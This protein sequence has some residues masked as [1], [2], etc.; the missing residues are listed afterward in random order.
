MKT[1]KILAFFAFIAM[2][3]AMVSC[4]QDDDFK[5][6]TSLGDEENAGLQAL[7][8][9]ATEV[10]IADVKAMYDSDPNNDGDNSDAMPFEVD[11]DIYVKG[12]VSSSD[13]TGN[14]FKE[15]YLQDSPSNPTGAL[16]VILNRVDTYNQ[17]NLG[18]EV[19]IS[20]KGLFIG[21]ERTGNGVTTIGGGTESD[22]YG[23]TVVSLNE[24]QIRLNLLRSTITET[25]IPLTLS[26]PQISN[27]NIGELVTVENVQFA[28][29]LEGKSYFDPIETFDTQRTL[30][31]C[32][33]LSYSEFKL[34]TSSF[35]SF[36]NEML[37]TGNGT[38]TA[39]VSKTFDGASLILA[40]NTTDDVN[41]T[42]ERCTLLDASDFT[43]IFEEDFQTATNNTDLDFAGWT[44]FAEA[45][46][47]VWRE[48]TFD[49]NGYTEFS[50]Y[51]SGDASNI[52]WL[53]TP[54]FDM[55]A[56][57]NEF[58]NFKSAQHHLESADN[59]LEVFVSTDYDGS[60]VLGATWE[61]IAAT[62]ASQA[63][64][65]YEFVDSGLIDLSSYTG[66]LY[67]AFKVVGSGTDTTLD[68]AYQIDDFNIVAT[69]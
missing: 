66:T 47:R 34:E 36:K 13:Q 31:I 12:Y 23:S 35:A 39:V 25:L 58:L 3:V 7:L 28:E 19:Y 53:V 9:N 5:V 48:K 14:F 26:F 37:P 20:L 69:N 1:N 4:V 42:G 50:T 41:L 43:T 54:G 65:W 16:K 27:A 55:D 56:Q 32:N 2:S 62:L 45:G 52:A 15:F 40:L 22:Q 38:L 64:D 11:T 68:G 59:T 67:V 29:D 63:N 46:S 51:S 61:P 49:G 10:S 17:F 8:A 24:N 44:N 57:D 18:R 33:G 30:Q 21:E 60:D 6:P